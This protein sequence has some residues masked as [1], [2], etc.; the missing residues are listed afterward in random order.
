MAASSVSEIG[1]INA[2]DSRMM[3]SPQLPRSKLSEIHSTEQTGV[4]LNTPWTFWLDKSIPGTSAAQYE[5]TLR[6]LYTV[7]TVQGFWAVYNNI[8]GVDMLNVRYTYHLMR[9]ERRPIWEDVNNCHGGNWRLKCNKVDSPTVWKELL[10]AAIGEQLSDNMAEGDE[11]GGMSISV[12]ERDDII[13]IWNKQS[14][15][16]EQ[17]TIIPKV[18]ELLPK[19]NFTAVFYKAFQTHQAFEGQKKL[20]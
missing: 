18:K 4:P 8:P 17:A 6:K 3:G 10:L 15:L 7:N 9:D 1:S 11:V 5:A 16:H 19:V 14:N 20:T 13:Q 2:T 12:R